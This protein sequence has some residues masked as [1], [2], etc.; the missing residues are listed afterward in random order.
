MAVMVDRLYHMKV[1]L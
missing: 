1:F